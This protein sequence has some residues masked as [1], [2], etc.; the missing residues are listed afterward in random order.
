MVAFQFKGTGWYVTDYGGRKSG[1]EGDSSAS[2]A[3]GK[4][5]KSG[6]DQAAEK[7]SGKTEKVA[8]K[9]V[10]AKSGTADKTPAPSR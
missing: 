1:A 8:E 3:P 2:E 4:S 10:S 9:A 7:A 6:S 5:E